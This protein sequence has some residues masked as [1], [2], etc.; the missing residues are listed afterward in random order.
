MKTSVK[1]QLY[2]QWLLL[3]CYMNYIANDKKKDVIEYS[4]YFHE[5]DVDYIK[6]H[7]LFKK[8]AQKESIA[9]WTRMIDETLNTF[10]ATWYKEREPLMKIV[11]KELDEIKGNESLTRVRLTETMT[12]KL[13]S[14]LPTEW[15]KHYTVM[16]MRYPVVELQPISNVSG[17]GVIKLTLTPDHTD[18]AVSCQY[19]FS[20]IEKKNQDAIALS[21]RTAADLYDKPDLIASIREKLMQYWEERK[22][23]EL[24]F[25]EK[26]D[27]VASDAIEKLTKIA[28]DFYYNTFKTFK[29]KYSNE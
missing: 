5:Y 28:R 3:H 10:R 4:E 11:D 12:E 25:G 15:Q 8:N 23:I 18:I 9:S 13:T 17:Y 2:E 14:L 19:L 29:W 24:E 7:G 26:A 21:W 27:A 20:G 16:P 22:K 1:E 6:A